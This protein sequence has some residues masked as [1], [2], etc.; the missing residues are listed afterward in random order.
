MKAEVGSVAEPGQSSPPGRNPHM[1][2]SKISPS[3]GIR[4]AR[5]SVFSAFRFQISAFLTHSPQ[6]LAFGIDRPA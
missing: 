3:R 5:F 6:A 4:P 2:A 1:R